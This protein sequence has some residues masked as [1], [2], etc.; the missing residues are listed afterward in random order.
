MAR[1]RYG[2]SVHVLTTHAELASA[3]SSTVLRALARRDYGLAA[4]RL[5]LVAQATCNDSDATLAD[6]FETSHKELLRNYR[7]EYVFKNLLISKVVF[8]HP[9]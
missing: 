9:W 6:A 2:C 3:F 8:G 5:S 7:N 4:G 1:Q